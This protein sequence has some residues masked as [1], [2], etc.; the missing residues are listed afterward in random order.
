MSPDAAVL[1]NPHENERRLPIPV[2]ILTGFLGSGKTTLI[3]HILGSGH[4]LKVAVI[5][6]DFG[7]I[8]IDDKLVSRRAQ[9]IVELANGCVCC[10]MQ[11]DLLRAIRQV[12]DGS[13][14]IDYILL[15][16]SGLSD[17]LPIA[18]SILNNGPDN[19]VRLDGTVTL[20][21]AMN[22]DDNLEHAEVAFSQLVNTDL[23]LINKIDLVEE[24]IPELIQQGIKKVNRYARMLACVN[25]N[26]DPCLLLDVRLSGLK[27]NG[28]MIPATED[29]SPESGRHQGHGLSEFDNISF[30]S[31]KPF[32]LE[33]FRAF[34]A[35]IPENVYRGK[36]ILNIAGDDFRRIFQLVG[37][38]CVVTRDRPWMPDEIRKTQ[39][40]LIGRRLGDTDLLTRL[41]H[42]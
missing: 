29:E 13:R 14:N 23:I 19:A 34:I 28:D 36:G 39:L 32:E 33:P 5:V 6:N 42:L 15:E 37:E 9:N 35:D 16:T 17:P 20:V 41:D 3:N 26:V 25:G 12:T 11:G 22:F 27:Q 1:S 10:S 21:D 7:D 8:S 2:T 30:E 24:H 4:G 18:A 40:V 31:P 38:R